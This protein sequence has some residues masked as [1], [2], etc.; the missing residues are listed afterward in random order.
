[1]TK[2][3]IIITGLLRSFDINYKKISNYFQKYDYDIYLCTSNQDDSETKYL[4][5]NNIKI[6]FNKIKY[7]LLID[8]SHINLDGE[9]NNLSKNWFKFYEISKIIESNK[10]NLIIKMRPDIYIID[11]LFNIDNIVLD[12]INIPEGYNIFNHEMFPTYNSINDQLLIFSPDKLKVISSFYK[13]ITNLKSFNLPLV[14]EILLYKYFEIHKLNINRIKMNYKLILSKCNI[15]ALCG[16]SGSGK[17]T[18]SKLIDPLLPKT[19]KLLLETDRY[20]KWE[21]GDINYE[22]YTHLN[23]YANHLE[24]MSEDVFKLKIGDNI[25]TVDYDHSTGKFTQVEKLESKTN[26]IL[27]GLHTLYTHKIKDI[28]DLKIYIDTDR[29]LIKKW[30][31]ER[32]TK[33]RGHSIEQVLKSLEKRDPDYFKYIEIQKHNSDVII[34]YYLDDNEIKLKIKIKNKYIDKINKIL[35]D[36]IKFENNYI[37]LDAK[38]FNKNEILKQINL[39]INNEDIKDDY[40]GFIQLLFYYL[41]YNDI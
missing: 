16:D 30:K 38:K 23:P 39:D 13:E 32:D 24:K 5:D 28:I 9:Y 22:N 6:D 8:D 29:E 4:T 35:I 33:Y 12:K 34:N 40:D 11:N 41:I 10:Y 15:I 7:Y 20:H 19:Q 3:C 37:V 25:Y 26:I 18:I 27:C 17:S 21:R 31:I 36:N 2:L 14:S 1:M